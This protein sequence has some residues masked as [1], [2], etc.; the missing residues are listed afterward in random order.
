VARNNDK[1]KPSAK[2]RAIAMILKKLE[3]GNY[4]NSEYEAADRKMLE[5]YLNG[6]GLHDSPAWYR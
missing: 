4:K 3:A 6:G 2:D 5:H 1:P